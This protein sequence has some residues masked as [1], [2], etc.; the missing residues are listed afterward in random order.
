MENKRETVWRNL[1]PGEI[2]II[3]ITSDINGNPVA[4]METKG[5]YNFSTI[6]KDGRNT[7]LTFSVNGSSYD[8]LVKYPDNKFYEV[9][10]PGIE[11]PEIDETICGICG[12]NNNE[13]SIDVCQSGH[14]FHID[15]FCNF[16][17]STNKPATQHLQSTVE[18][19]G[20]EHIIDSGA[21]FYVPLR[22]PNCNDPILP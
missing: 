21:N 10:E 14:K 17:N 3:H 5:T 4:P 11:E 16:A 20:V 15:C 7:I 2:Y 13:F 9:I 8:V 6:S 19:H 18:E 22:C 12:D 1:N